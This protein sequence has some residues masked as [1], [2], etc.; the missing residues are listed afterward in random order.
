ME[1]RG[2]ISTER[3]ACYHA[4]YSGVVMGALGVWKGADLSALAVLI[5]AITMPLMWYAGNRT[6]LKRK[7]GESN[8]D[9]G[10]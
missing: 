10:N 5:G 2:Q 1:T 3:K 7:Q 9:N 4:F 6:A 8:V